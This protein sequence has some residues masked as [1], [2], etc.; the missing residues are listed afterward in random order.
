MLSEETLHTLD[1]VS[2][3]YFHSDTMY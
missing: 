3:H 2:I 1:C